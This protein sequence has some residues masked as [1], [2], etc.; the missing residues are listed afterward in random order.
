MLKAAV[1]DIDESQNVI[2]KQGS[3]ACI[4]DWQVKII[5]LRRLNWGS[6]WC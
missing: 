4:K 1:A 2:V 6:S 3:I 5:F